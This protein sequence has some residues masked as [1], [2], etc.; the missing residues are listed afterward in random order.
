MKK[1]TEWK[2]LVCLFMVVMLFTMQEMPIWSEEIVAKAA[3]REMPKNP[4]HHCT[5]DDEEDEYGE[6]DTTEW[7]YIYFGSYPQTEV[8]GEALT[9]VITGASYDVNGDAW[10]DGVKYRRISKNDTNYS[11]YFEDS[12]YRYFKWER[13]RWKVLQNDGSTLFVV[14]DKGLDCKRYN[15]EDESVTWENCTIRK[16]LNNDFFY[17]AFN[18]SEKGAIVEQIVV[19]EDNLDYGTEGGNDTLDNVYLLSFGEVTNPIYGFCE[20][21]YMF[22]SSRCF[23]SSDYAHMRGGN[24]NVGNCD[25]W[26]RSPGFNTYNV[27]GVDYCGHIARRGDSVNAE[28]YAVAPALH[29][30]LSSDLWSMAVDSG[31]GDSGDSNDAKEAFLQSA[32][33]TYGSQSYDVLKTAHSI[34]TTHRPF[35]LYCERRCFRDKV[36]PVFRQ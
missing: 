26:L 27:V 24:I 12:D 15:E 36:C 9:E 4:V 18:S 35:D 10:V 5:K 14:A 1:R 16:W 32:I 2:R 33:Y 29:I 20:K 22:S 21:Y 25:W 11:G 13:I 28:Y 19:N 31:S 6:H 8:T 7:S 17:L 30:N 34:E 23:E 3:E